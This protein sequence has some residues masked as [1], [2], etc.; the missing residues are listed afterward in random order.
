MGIAD[1]VRPVQGEQVVLCFQSDEV[2]A[3][4]PPGSTAVLAVAV[5]LA[6]CVALIVT[7]SVLLGMD[8]PHR[9]ELLFR[10]AL[11]IML[12][13]AL[14]AATTVFT[15][16]ICPAHDDTGAA[17]LGGGPGNPGPVAVDAAGDSR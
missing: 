6:Q 14:A 17:R 9:P 11:G 4:A 10:L 2:L 5:A 12:V 1:L 7:G 8:L 13:A 15:R 3:P 16:G